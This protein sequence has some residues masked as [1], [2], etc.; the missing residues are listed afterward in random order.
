[1]DFLRRS[2]QAE[3]IDDPAIPFPEIQKN[4]QEL[5]VINTWLGGHAISI[6]GI[7]KIFRQHASGRD[8]R[9]HICEIGCGGGDNLHAIASWC[10]AQKINATFTGIDINRHCIEY[11]SG[12]TYPQQ[13]QFI[14]QDYRE[15]NFKN[16]PD[17]I[18]NSLFCHHFTDKEIVEMLRWMKD[19]SVCGFFINDL[20]RH[21]VAYHLIKHITKIFSS[22]RLVK[23]DAPLS[24]SRGFKASEW[25]IL[26]KNAA[27]P[28][29]NITWKWAFRY[30]IVFNHDLLT[31]KDAGNR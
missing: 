5:D 2:Y 4:L 14:E 28:H 21:P 13:V 29:A 25:K 3:L 31:Y 16:K 11:A 12:K 6:K 26:L 18:F 17:I 1:M 22:S 20:H 7:K 10:I 23:N 27:I 19:Q 30:L 9:W 15:V 24:V 8:Y